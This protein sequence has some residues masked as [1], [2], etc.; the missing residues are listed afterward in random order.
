MFGLVIETGFDMV[1]SYNKGL[2]CKLDLG[3][4]I[5]VILLHQMSVK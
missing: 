2:A 1:L 4:I 3:I 5:N